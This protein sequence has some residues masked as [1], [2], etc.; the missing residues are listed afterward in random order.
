MA[1]VLSPARRETLW[2][3][4]ERVLDWA[5]P[6]KDFILADCE[7]TLAAKPA[8][9]RLGVGLYLWLLRWLPV[10]TDRCCFESLSAARKDE[11]LRRLQFHPLL[12][13][14]VGFW[15][16]RTLVL[17]AHYG[18]PGVGPGLGYAPVDDGNAKLLEPRP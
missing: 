14:R 2:A 1:P 3:L 5:G 17:I 4:A 15:G 9:L 18:K 7:R 6:D 16:V 13:L 10:L 8:S 11:V 12:P